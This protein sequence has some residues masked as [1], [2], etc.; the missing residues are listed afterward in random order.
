MRY[1][2]V[3]D[4]HGNGDAFRA[5]LRTVRRKRFDAT[6]VLGDL[7]GYGASPDHVVELLN[8]LPGTVHTVRGNHDK[9]AAGIDDGASFNA[10]ALAAARW[11]MERMTAS[12][13]KLV[14]ELPEGPLVIEDGDPPKLAI[15]HGSPADEDT[16]LFA[17]QEAWSGFQAAPGAHVTFFG[18]THLPSVF[19]QHRG[20][21]RAV[22]LRGNR[23]RLRL[24][25]GLR[26]L[27]NPGSV[28][29]PRDRNPLAS[30]MMFD[31][32]SQVVS[33]KRVRYPI[34]RAQRRIEKAGLPKSLAERL[35]YGM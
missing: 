17:E 10:A 9:V 13:L 7:V 34:R 14:R 30:F 4:M 8:D 1:L 19:I 29:Q 5:V 33:W 27:I 32:E 26:Y 11:T 24:H 28:G 23:G 15:C 6:L 25:P 22:L 3:S 12:N 20:G 21:V 18:H 2:I 31:S 35:S 16:Y